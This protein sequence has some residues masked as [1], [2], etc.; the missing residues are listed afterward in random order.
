MNGKPIK[1]KQVREMYNLIMSRSEFEAAKIKLK[2]MRRKI[3]ATVD[4]GENTITFV[5]KLTHEDFF[6]LKA[7]VTIETAVNLDALRRQQG[8]ELNYTIEL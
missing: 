8:G 4:I 5:V 1:Q 3:I 2:Q 6:V 7:T